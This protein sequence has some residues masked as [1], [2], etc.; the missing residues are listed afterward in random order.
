MNSVYY[1]PNEQSSVPAP[2]YFPVQLPVNS[3][4]MSRSVGTHESDNSHLNITPVVQYKMEPF[5]RGSL[6]EKNI[7]Y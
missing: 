1:H 5:E 2:V 3:Y 6:L 4:I 7:S